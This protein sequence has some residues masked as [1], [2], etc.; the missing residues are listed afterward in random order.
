[1][2]ASN[3]SPGRNRSFRAAPRAAAKQPR[4]GVNPNTTRPAGRA[5]P[6]ASPTQWDGHLRRA[7][8]RHPWV[9]APCKRG[10]NPDC[11]TPSVAACEGKPRAS[12]LIDLRASSPATK[13]ARIDPLPPHG[14]LAGRGPGANAG[15]GVIRWRALRSRRGSTPTPAVPQTPACAFV[16]RLL[17]GR[18]AGQRGMAPTPPRAAPTLRTV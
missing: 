18:V 14:T 10:H 17:H 5:H 12:V 1:M 15:T 13:A 8:P 4:F 7:G 11:R 16:R 6:R 3:H 2:A 9:L